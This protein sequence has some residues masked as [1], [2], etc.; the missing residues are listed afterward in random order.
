MKNLIVIFFSLFLLE[1]CTRYQGYS[2]LTP[3]I[4]YSLKQFGDGGSK[5]SVGDYVTLSIEYR[6]RE[7]SVFF[8]GVRKLK[9]KEPLNNASVDHCFVSISKGDSSSFILPAA[10]FFLQTLKREL[11]DF[12]AGD[13]VMKLNVRLLEIQ[14]SR[15]FLIEKQLFLT[16]SAELSEYENLVLQKF[17]KEENP[18]IKPK[19]E[20]FYMLTISQG[21]LRRVSKGDHVWVHY[22]GKF[23]DGKF[24]DGTYRS[25]EP[26]D[27][28][29]GTQFVLI[30][31]L[32]QAMSY[33]TE[34]EK[35]MVILP[36][37]LAFGEKG[38]DFGIIPPYTSL[39]YTLEI[40]KIE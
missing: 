11:P 12:L 29:Y 30:P 18:G 33:M 8:K 5:P 14:S 9:L 21:N 16:W 4:Y 28:I 3:E 19:P 17:L 24:F 36:S 39:I 38:D 7:D 40:V 25:H 2:K 26:V 35:S 10:G 1:S 15:D 6:T 31:G 37:G 22:E 34:G 32:D 13:E 23:L 27:F 20:G